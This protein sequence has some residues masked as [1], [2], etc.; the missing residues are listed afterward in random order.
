MDAEAGNS[1]LAV[2]SHGGGNDDGDSE[3]REKVIYRGTKR[4]PQTS[5]E[6]KTSQE[7]VWETGKRKMKK[8]WRGFVGLGEKTIGDA[9]KVGGGVKDAGTRLIEDVTGIL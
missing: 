6:S 8:L 4:K 2:D 1:T 7:S 3:R 5:D 9:R